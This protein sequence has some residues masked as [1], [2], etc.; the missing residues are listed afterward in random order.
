MS[1]S[2]NWDGLA[3]GFDLYWELIE[4]GCVEEFTT[5][6]ITTEEHIITA[7]STTDEVT[8]DE[9]TTADSN[10]NTSGTISS[11]HPYGYEINKLW[12]FTP[13][14]TKFARFHFSKFN[15]EPYNDGVA[16]TANGETYSFSGNDT[17]RSKILVRLRNLVIFGRK[18][19]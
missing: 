9:V 14:P 15:T 1:N 18:L 3:Y 6:Q 4:N 7:E 5:P 19:F 12:E 8:T 16:V 11:E 17:V 2:N 10:Y 13:L